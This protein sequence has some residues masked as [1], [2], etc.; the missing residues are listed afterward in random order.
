VASKSLAV[1]AETARQGECAICLEE[2]GEGGAVKMI[3]YCKHVFHAECIDRWLEKQV[4]CP[5]CRCCC[6]RC[7]EVESVTVR[8]GEGEG[9]DTEVI[10]VTNFD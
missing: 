1:V 2:V 9:E 8:G 3:A 6:E 5:V 7:G 10:S 4:T